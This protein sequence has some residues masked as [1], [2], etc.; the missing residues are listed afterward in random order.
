M[1]INARK[2]IDPRWTSH[3]VPVVRSFMLAD[4]RIIRRSKDDGELTY[5]QNSGTYSSSS[6]TE[7]FTG[8][9]R[10]QPYGII[11]DIIDAQDTTGRRLMRVQVEGKLTGISLDDM[12][13]IDSCPDDP[14]LTQFVLEVRGS[15]GSSNSWVTDLVC[16][17][18]LKKL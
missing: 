14:E 4:I 15:I 12:L 8:K 3:F 13:F 17:A 16:E 10:I 5:D 1:G 2:A 7:V 18:N 11:G 9:A 6:I